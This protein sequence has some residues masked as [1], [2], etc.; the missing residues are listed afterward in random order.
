MNKNKTYKSRL[1]YEINIIFIKLHKNPKPKIWTSEVL[2][3][4]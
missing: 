1:K 4:F 3:F 2:D